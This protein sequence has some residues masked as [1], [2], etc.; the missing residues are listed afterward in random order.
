MVEQITERI[1]GELRE[2]WV[3]TKA[4]TYVRNILYVTDMHY[5]ANIHYVTVYV[6]DILY[7]TIT[8]YVTDI[9]YVTDILYVKVRNLYRKKIQPAT[10][11]ALKGYGYTCYMYN[12]VVRYQLTSLRNKLFIRRV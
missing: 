11:E 10:K 7:V 9:H 12:K 8:L 4:Q 3:E 1:N 5:V 6:T 2:Y